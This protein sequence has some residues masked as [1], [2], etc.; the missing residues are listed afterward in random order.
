M[1]ILPRKI[2]IVSDGTTRGTHV[3][4]EDGTLLGGVKAIKINIEADQLE[5]EVQLVIIGV[6]IEICSSIFHKDDG[7]DQVVINSNL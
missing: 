4:L 6:P 1:G 2:K 5:S 7:G 3:V